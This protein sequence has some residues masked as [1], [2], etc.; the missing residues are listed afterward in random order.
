MRKV[1]KQNNTLVLSGLIGAGL[2]SVVQLT[3]VSVLSR[4]LLVAAFCFSVSIP[5]MAAAIFVVNKESDK[6]VR[7][8]ASYVTLFVTGILLSVSG[9]SALF[10]HFHYIAGTAFI[11][12]AIVASALAFRTIEVS[13]PITKSTVKGD[14]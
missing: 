6:P 3:S 11:V 4:S 1:H 7:A 10:Y 14:H 5:V 9:I 8:T 13:E 2:I 12:S